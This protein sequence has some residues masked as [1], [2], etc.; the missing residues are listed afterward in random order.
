MTTEVDQ[1]LAWDIIIPK[2]G[3]QSQMKISQQNQRLENLV[4]TNA[5]NELRKFK[6]H[7]QD[8][9]YMYV[10][11]SMSILNECLNK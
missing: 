10:T 5:E 7:I 2:L 4:Q 1:S 8:D 9:K 3:F 11:Y 6:C